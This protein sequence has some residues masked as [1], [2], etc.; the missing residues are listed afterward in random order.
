MYYIISIKKFLV[1][2]EATMYIF[3]K[4]IDNI[5]CM[6]YFNYFDF[7]IL[8]LLNNDLQCISYIY[9]SDFIKTNNQTYYN[10]RKYGFLLIN[11]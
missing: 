4:C 9:D 5:I 3:I 11:I 1:L 2:F 6:K 8:I 10:T 7:Q